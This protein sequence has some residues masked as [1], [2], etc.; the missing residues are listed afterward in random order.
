MPDH[1]TSPVGE[2]AGLLPCPFCGG[3]NIDPAE[4]SGND[5]KSGPGCGDCGALGESIEAW[6]RRAAPALDASGLPP[7][8]APVGTIYPG[9]YWTA[10]VQATPPGTTIATVY[11]A[12]QVRQAQRDAVAADRKARGQMF[13]YEQAQRH[14]AEAVAIRDAEIADLRAQLVRL[15]ESKKENDND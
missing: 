12:E 14:A 8:S 1:Q 6:N 11:T 5:G 15:T 10:S 3:T 7:L 13:T 4:W 9:N 2:D